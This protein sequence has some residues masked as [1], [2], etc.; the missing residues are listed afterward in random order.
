LAA[1]ELS[2]RCLF[3]S[4][5]SVWSFVQ[6]C[7]PVARP[8]LGFI[9]QGQRNENQAVSRLRGTKSRREVAK[10]WH[11]TSCCPDTTGRSYGQVYAPSWL[12]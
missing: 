6:P 9:A 1:R 5:G 10:N 11:W 7:E 3:S 2:L 8:V 12:S 4:T